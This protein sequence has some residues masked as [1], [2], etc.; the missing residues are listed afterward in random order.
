MRTNS[1]LHAYSRW[2]T[3]P[4]VLTFLMRP[5]WFQ[6]GQLVRALTRSL[7]LTGMIRSSDTQ[8]RHGARAHTA[9]LP[10][11]PYRARSGPWDQRPMGG[12]GANPV[13]SQDGQAMHGAT[14]TG[15]LAG[16]AYQGG[17]GRS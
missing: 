13:G 3:V 1:P 2:S 10:W 6:L 9:R 12:R 16:R 17:C 7:T 8:T 14:A 5:R 11:K 4:L 15:P